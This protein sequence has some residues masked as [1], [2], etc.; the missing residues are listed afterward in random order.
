MQLLGVAGRILPGRRRHS[1]PVLAYKRQLIL[2]SGM[3]E[4]MFPDRFS[5]PVWFVCSVNFLFMTSRATGTGILVKRELTSKDTK[6]FKV[7][8]TR[9]L[10]PLYERFD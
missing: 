4:N 8:S 9:Y 3:E 2:S 10:S 1:C 6:D 5:F 7:L